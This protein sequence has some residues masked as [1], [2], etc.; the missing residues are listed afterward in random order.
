MT[1][2]ESV[3]SRLES[4]SHEQPALPST[5]VESVDME[6]DDAQQVSRV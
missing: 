1:C 5:G 2:D 3:K 6:I 4:P